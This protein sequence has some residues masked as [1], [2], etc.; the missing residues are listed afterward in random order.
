MLRGWD[1][2]LMAGLLGPA[3]GLGPLEDGQVG[4]LLSWVSQSLGRRSP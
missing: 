2:G 3:L 1:P 4:E